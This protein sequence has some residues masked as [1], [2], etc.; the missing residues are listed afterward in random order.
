MPFGREE[1]LRRGTRGGS[2]M[3]V[4]AAADELVRHLAAEAD[5]LREHSSLMV[6]ARAGA[7]ALVTRV[8]LAA[9]WDQNAALPVMSPV[10]ARVHEVETGWL[11]GLLGLPAGSAA[12]FVTGAAMANTAALT[13]ARDQQLAQAGW[14]VQADGLSGAPELTVIAGRKPIPR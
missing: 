7:L 12:A 1:F 4:M 14:D 9:A 11:A 8:E 10:A 3:H 2:T 6:L 5:P 13:A